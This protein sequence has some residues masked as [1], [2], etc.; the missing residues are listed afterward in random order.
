M[1]LPKESY[2]LFLLL[3]L[4]FRHHFHY[5]NY[6]DPRTTLTCLSPTLIEMYNSNTDL[7]IPPEVWCLV[8]GYLYPSE[9]GQML[10]LNKFFRDMVVG[11]L[12][13]KRMYLTNFLLPFK[14]LEGRTE[15]ETFMMFVGVYRLHICE[16]CWTICSFRGKNMA[17]LPVY[18]PIARNQNLRLC[19]ECRVRCFKAN[20]QAQQAALPDYIRQESL[21]RRTML[22]RYPGSGQAFPL[23]SLF[24]KKYKVSVINREMRFIHGGQEGVDASQRSA[25]EANARTRARLI[26][27]GE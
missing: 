25:L 22:A 10:L 24:I 5:D 2:A 26:A 15:S 4:L 1:D 16:D 20:V 3:L 14:S 23:N 17:D 12:I 19:R 6:F 7:G 11:L 18:Y 8:L 13:W 21:S 9:L 27:Y